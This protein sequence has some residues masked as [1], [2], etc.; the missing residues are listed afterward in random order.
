MF[1][2]FGYGAA[3]Y[4]DDGEDVVQVEIG[5]GLGNRRLASRRE[6]NAPITRMFPTISILRMEWSVLFWTAPACSSMKEEKGK[7]LKM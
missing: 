2:T 6:G 5:H 4:D 3:G 7:K 1:F